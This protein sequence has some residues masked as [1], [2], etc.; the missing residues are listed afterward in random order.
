MFLA[1]ALKEQTVEETSYLPPQ[2]L[3]RF[4]HFKATAVNNKKH[5]VAFVLF[6]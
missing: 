1:Y 3:H 4:L 2:A 6:P 5:Q